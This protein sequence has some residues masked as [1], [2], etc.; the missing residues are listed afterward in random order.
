M[1]LVV[2][3]EEVDLEVSP[4]ERVDTYDTGFKVIPVLTNNLRYLPTFIPSPCPPANSCLNFFDE[5]PIER[6]SLS[7]VMKRFMISRVDFSVP[8]REAFVW[9]DIFP[10]N[11]RG[12]ELS[13]ALNS[14]F[15]PVRGLRSVNSIEMSTMERYRPGISSN[16]SRQFWRS[17]RIPSS[18]PHVGVSESRCLVAQGDSDLLGQA[19]Q[20]RWDH[21]PLP[22]SIRLP[23]LLSPADINGEI[24]S[25]S[26]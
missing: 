7:N 18:N 23:S 19:C 5:S 15:V 10:S 17:S 22:S 9:K 11:W 14:N 6:C 20:V 26:A 24:I 13:N 25:G 16:P 8:S 3:R 2:V 21:H 4:Q 1:P 12:L